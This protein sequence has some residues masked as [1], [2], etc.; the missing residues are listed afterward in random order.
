MKAK[1]AII[2][3]R[4]STI[5]QE[6]EAQIS[7]L[8]KYAANLGY[9][10]FKIVANKESG[11]KSFDKREGFDEVIKIIES[12]EG[13]NTI[14]CTELSRLSRN[15]VV[16]QQIKEYL[17]TNKIQLIVK[18]AAFFLL[19]ENGNINSNTNMV[20]S[21][22]ASMAA[23]EMQKIKRFLRARKALAA[24]GYSQGGKE[25][26]GYTRVF[27]ETRRKSTYVINEEEKAQIIDIFNK[28]INET[29]SIR[30]LT[31]YCIAKGYSKYLHSKRN[32]TKL[33]SEEAY[34]G[35]K[36]THNRRKNAEYF[37][38]GNLDAPKYIECDS[39][40][41]KYPQIISK[42]LFELAQQK[43]RDNRAN[44][45]KS[46]KNIT[47]LSKLIRCAN[48][49]RYLTADYRMRGRIM[50]HTYRCSQRHTVNDCSNKSSYS[51]TLLDSVIWQFVKANVTN[52]VTRLNSENNDQKQKDIKTYIENI[53]AQIQRVVDGIKTAKKIFEIDRKIDPDYAIST[54]AKKC[55][56]I[57][58]EKELLERER[59]SYA[60][61]LERIKASK[62]IDV[63]KDIKAR[64]IEIE[65]N[66][67]LLSDYI[68]QLI[69][70]IRII[71]NNPSYLV[72]EV[73]AVEDL[74]YQLRMDAKELRNITSK[75]PKEGNKIEAQLTYY[76]MISKSNGR[77]IKVRYMPKFGIEY[78][79]CLFYK[80]N[81]NYKSAGISLEEIFGYDLEARE[82]LYTILERDTLL[83]LT[84][85]ARLHSLLFDVEDLPFKRLEV[86]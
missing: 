84:K 26:F 48:C 28:Y 67:Q 73:D 55:E 85:D 37:N 59:D 46:S 49:G 66:R 56:D 41:M 33:L 74:G 83:K 78:I 52:L 8:K 61:K 60:L 53:N 30:D 81:D 58:K 27:D 12:G 71:S 1:K 70:E 13:Y 51:L 32:V 79:N 44:A 20:F 57:A 11:F 43:K 45:D 72:A 40:E 47:I 36:V 14:I 86:Y 31:L 69:S 23:S 9:T 22:F 77:L 38:Y 34:T 7:D 39:R 4:V 68:H 24:E 16:L 62:K 80:V 17:K 82:K 64:I 5:E 25:L 65:S 35:Y 50:A 75:S 21:I 15:E 10:D 18:D 19:D 3:A 29:I 2:L 42:N 63:E 76:I 54:Y 6:Y